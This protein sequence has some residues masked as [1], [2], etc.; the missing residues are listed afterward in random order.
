MHLLTR[1]DDEWLLPD[2]V[3]TH[4][5]AQ[6]EVQ[7]LAKARHELSPG[8]NAVAVKLV[9]I[10]GGL[11]LRL[12]LSLSLQRGGRGG[13]MSERQQCAPQARMSVFNA[14]STI[15]YSQPVPL[16]AAVYSPSMPFDGNCVWKPVHMTPSI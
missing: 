9:F 12:S 8:C 16:N 5:F 6:A 15:L 3:L 14:V 11:T 13:W 4:L 1:E 7:V 2:G 10:R